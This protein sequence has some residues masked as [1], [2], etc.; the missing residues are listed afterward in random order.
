MFLPVISQRKLMNDMHQIWDYAQLVALI[1]DVVKG[2]WGITALYGIYSFVRKYTYKRVNLSIGS[3][4]V[5]RKDFNVRNLTNIV[6]ANFYNG[7]TIPADVRKEII[8]ITSP[9]VKK[10]KANE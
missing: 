5:K 9:K 7:D 2:C 10:L 1:V 3:F 4:E 6:S 8:L